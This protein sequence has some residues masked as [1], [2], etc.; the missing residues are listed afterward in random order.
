YVVDEL[1]V[2]EIT[3]SSGQVTRV[4]GTSSSATQDGIGTIA[5][6]KKLVGV[7]STGDYLYA[8]DAGSC[9]VRR[10]QIST[11]NVV[12]FA[13]DL[14]ECWES[15]SAVGTNAFFYEPWGVSFGPNGDNSV[16]YVASKSA[17]S[18]I[19]VSSAQVT[20]IAGAKDYTSYADGVAL[21]GYLDNPQSIFTSAAGRIYLGEINNRIR[22]FEFDG[23]T[24]APTFVSNQTT[25]EPVTMSPVTISPVTTSPV[26]INPVTA[27][28][29]TISPV[30]T[31]PV[32]INP[33]TASPVTISPVTTSPVTISPVTTSPVTVSPSFS[34]TVN[35]VTISP[36][37]LAPLTN[38]PL[39]NSPLTN[40]PLTNSPLTNSPLTNSPLTNSPISNSPTSSPITNSPGNSPLTM[41]PVS[42]HPATA[43]PGSTHPATSSPR[44]SSPVTA[45]PA[46]SHPGTAHPGSS[47]PASSSPVT[48]SPVTSSPVTLSPASYH[49]TT[50]QPGSM[51]PATTSPFTAHPLT[52]SPFTSDPTLAPA[53]LHPGSTQ[54]T[55]GPTQLPTS[56]PSVGPSAYP[57]PVATAPVLA[58]IAPQEVGTCGILRIDTSV[59]SIGT[60]NL[61]WFLNS[62]PIP[63]AIQDGLI[64][65]Y[66]DLQAHATS[67]GIGSL[68]DG[69][70]LNFTAKAFDQA[71]G[72]SSSIEQAIV[73]HRGVM[74]PSLILSGPSSSESVRPSEPL[75]LS[76][77]V[78]H[79]SCLSIT[80]SDLASLSLEY[81]W[82]ITAGGS[83]L[84]LSLENS[85]EIIVPSASLLPSQTHQVIVRL[86]GIS[87]LYPGLSTVQ[88]S[89]NVNVG[90]E[91]VVAIISTG[92][93]ASV[94]LGRELVLDGSKSNDPA[95]LLGATRSFFWSCT[96]LLP[97]PTSCTSSLTPSPTGETAILSPNSLL[98]GALFTVS[99]TFTVSANLG[100]SIGLITRS[101]NTSTS[102]T[103]VANAPFVSLIHV[104][105]PTVPSPG[106]LSAGSALRLSSTVT[107]DPSSS[108]APSELIYSWS[109]TSGLLDGLSSS[110]RLSSLGAPVLV[111]AGGSLTPGVTYSFT[112]SVTDPET[113]GTGQT[114]VRVEVL[115]APSVT[116]VA[117]SPSAGDVRETVFQLVAH[118][119][120]SDSSQ[121]PLNYQFLV[122]KVGESEMVVGNALKENAK[123]I[124]L[125]QSGT[126]QV[127]VEVRDSFGSMA[128]LWASGTIDVQPA[129][130]FQDPCTALNTTNW[131]LIDLLRGA[132]YSSSGESSCIGT[133]LLFHLDLLAS[134]QVHFA[135]LEASNYILSFIGSFP[136]DIST[137]CL[138]C[139]AHESYQSYES[140]L[141]SKLIFLLETPSNSSAYTSQTAQTLK[142]LT[143]SPLTTN[144]TVTSQSALVSNLLALNPHLSPTSTTGVRTSSVIASALSSLALAR[145]PRA[146][147][148]TRELLVGVS[149]DM[150]PGEDPAVLTTSAFDAHVQAL[151]ATSEANTASSGVNVTVPSGVAANRTDAR[152]LIVSWEPGLPVDAPMADNQAGESLASNVEDVTLTDSNGNNIAIPDGESI[153]IAIPLKEGEEAS[154][155]MRC[156]YIQRSEGTWSEDGCSLEVEGRGVACVCTHLTEFAVMRRTKNGQPLP[157]SLRMTYVCG[158]AVAW[159]IAMVAGIQGYRLWAIKAHRGWVA[160]VHYLLTFQ[161]LSRGL[162]S[163]MYSGV[164]LHFNLNNSHGALVVVVSALPYT[165]SFW[166]ASL[167]AFQW[168]ASAFNPRLRTN[169]FHENRVKY[170]VSNLVVVFIMWAFFFAFW[171]LD[172][173]VI[174]YVGPAAMAFACLVLVSLYL[175]GGLT[176][177]HKLKKSFSI[178]KAS[179]RSLKIRKQISH[180][181]E[182]GLKAIANSACFLALS[183]VWILSAVFRDDE[184]VLKAIVPLFLFIDAFDACLI[185]Y[186]YFRSVR[187]TVRKSSIS[188][189]SNSSPQTSK[190]SSRRVTTRR[191]TVNHMRRPLSRRDSHKGRH[192]SKK[193]LYRIPT[194]ERKSRIEVHSEADISDSSL[195]R[196]RTIG[197][198]VGTRRLESPRQTGRKVDPSP[199]I[200]IK[201]LSRTN[202]ETRQDSR[203][204]GT[205]PLSPRKDL[206]VASALNSSNHS[207]DVDADGES[208]VS[209]VKR[210]VI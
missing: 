22:T 199:R 173:Q 72:L 70:I 6:F 26:T 177:S 136:T 45:F 9:V 43:H 116:S 132:G 51:H 139:T 153:R 2:R 202:L 17:I 210:I 73:T 108:L 191:Y 203:P 41:S 200:K 18:K 100:G 124:T 129:Y 195:S 40:S 144:T 88:T 147:D 128:K 118:A 47:H 62:Y 104:T 91:A 74:Q 138:S 78:Q 148:L 66:S 20:R 99:L 152:L 169:N 52:S 206:T 141:F 67:S 57:T 10:I 34:P 39:T 183:I 71:T 112:V 185:L 35:P 145:D 176:I 127:G 28:P 1:T 115:L 101:S 120:V 110:T 21:S 155:D 205:Y 48:S 165:F 85:P 123:G 80:S 102:L 23:F 103:A 11:K 182:V 14:Y 122:R 8:A 27:S 137:P 15:T 174:S 61:S 201:S 3:L 163:L 162:S 186:M 117:F 131:Y 55:N 161:G 167:I 50:A 105:S 65:S 125:D 172:M 53:T 196:S 149:T 79:A 209:M 181:E 150:I 130:A 92:D 69:S 198:P 179:R 146:D 190:M 194:S 16:L 36:Q 114:S 37:T 166:T 134:L 32:T 75:R 111:V 7:A 30:T 171:I 98:S 93:V 38:S 184:T 164:L 12:T 119:T 180:S 156:V 77:T 142:A 24:I 133:A 58:L 160:I 89:L 42:S 81:A 90:D 168:M 33:A 5:R 59:Q 175:I 68:N 109:D 204:I 76:L 197:S 87:S 193:D 4:A 140:N 157:E 170:Y 31:S 83:S 208:S 64:L 95:G 159:M 29:V 106:R 154:G 187:H 54:P 113:G 25:S 97:S 56:D 178:M 60:V 96:S 63:S 46:S 49:P 84:G 158:A 13:G 143:A 86:S 189:S 121:T 207:G 192:G 44:T 135:I 188:V 126:F 151:V 107:L 82:D 94:P 19:V